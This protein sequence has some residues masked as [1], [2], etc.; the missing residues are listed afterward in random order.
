MRTAFS[1]RS[2]NLLNFHFG[3]QV[4]ASNIGDIFGG[5]YMYKIGIPI[6][7]IFVVWAGIFVLRLLLRPFALSLCFQRGL[8]KS[9]ILGT[10]TY[11]TYFLFLGKIEGVGMWLYI[12]M[13]ASAIID[14]LYWLPYHT[15]FSVL[16]DTEHRGKQIGMRE[17]ALLLAGLL[18]PVTGGIIINTYGFWTAFFIASVFMLLSALPL[19]STPEVTIE[20]NRGVADA[21]KNVSK[22]GFY[23]YM[24]DGF[25]YYTHIF[26]W[27]LVLFLFLDD[28]VS[29]G[30]LLSLAVLFQIMGSFLT[31]HLFDTGSGK[32]VY[33]LGIFFIVLGTIG[34]VFFAY[35]IPLIIFFDMVMMAG[36]ALYYPIMTSAYYNTAKKSH[37]PLWFQYFSEAG[38]DVGSA[39][40]SLL[41]A[42]FV[43]ISGELRF[44]MLASILG[45]V[46]TADFLRRY[47]KN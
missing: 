33:P 35:T 37:C 36:A 9:V 46:I 4:F 14:I 38:W 27:T 41:A 25:S 17:G 16:G 23:L 2:I 15:Y 20:R 47:Y 22:Q 5:I 11:S 40:G 43:Y 24:G 28:Y 21:L 31:G 18:T 6:W 19:L 32:R 39:L 42:L 10:L 3:L 44:V 8:R 29:F 34:R 26:T 30:G 45:M 7:M 12:F 1:N 13:A